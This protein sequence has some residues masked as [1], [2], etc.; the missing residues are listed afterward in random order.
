[1]HVQG[2]VEAARGH[3]APRARGHGTAQT[4]R[5]FP[6]PRPRFALK[7]THRHASRLW[8]FSLL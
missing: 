8:G 7:Q 4:Q 6:E 1:M 2:R 5:P 3:S